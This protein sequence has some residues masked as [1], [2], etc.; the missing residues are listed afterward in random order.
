MSGHVCTRALSQGAARVCRDLVRY[1]LAVEL[2][3]Y[4]YCSQAST[5]AE[6]FYGDHDSLCTSAAHLNF[7]EPYP[8]RLVLL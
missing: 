5:Q 3:V 2:D 4:I 8:L 7:W 1:T 6:L